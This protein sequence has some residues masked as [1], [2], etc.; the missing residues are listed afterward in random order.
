VLIPS[1]ADDPFARLSGCHGMLH[2]RPAVFDRGKIPQIQS[3][4]MQA[5]V[6]KMQM[7]IHDPRR[8]HSAWKLDGA[9][10]STARRFHFLVGP[11]GKN[12]AV[13]DAQ[14]LRPGS[15]RIAAEDP[16]GKYRRFHVYLR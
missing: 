1:T 4:Q 5:E 2:P 11:Y 13:F 12:P 3:L 8:D 15:C 10:P 14:G 6:H 16:G 7:G 9:S